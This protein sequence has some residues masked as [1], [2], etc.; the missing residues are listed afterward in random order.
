MH[1]AMRTVRSLALH[2]SVLEDRPHPAWC[3]GPVEEERPS[4]RGALGE[5]GS[6]GRGGLSI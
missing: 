2:L 6:G 4:V 5:A 3:S 1:P